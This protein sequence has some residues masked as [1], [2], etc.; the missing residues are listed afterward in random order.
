MN[1][2]KILFFDIDGTIYRE[3]S[4]IYESAASAIYE[5]ANAG[6]LMMLC[7]G[8]GMSTIPDEVRAL[9]FTGGVFGCGTHVQIDHRV[10]LDA[11]V[12]GSCCQDVLDILYRNDCPYFVNNSDYIYYDPDFLPTNRRAMAKRMYYAYHGR[13]R[14]ME[15][16]PG[17]I[18]KLTAYPQDTRL[19]PQ[20][21]RDLSPWFDTIVHAEYDYIELVLK[22]CT[23]GTGV[24]LILQDLGIAREN[25]YG[26]GDSANDLPLLDA[27]GHAVIM[28]DAPESIKGSFQRAASIHDDGLARSLKA[29]G[30]I[31]AI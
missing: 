2:R 29:L 5:C 9:P 21:Q 12:M 31:G 6:H 28:G 8:R 27:V 22:G 3:G 10:L 23:K 24:D 18:S 20:I 25:S 19:I 26:F 17:R 4:G 1:D 11:A 30:L 16:N 13:L 15:E 7:T 14:P